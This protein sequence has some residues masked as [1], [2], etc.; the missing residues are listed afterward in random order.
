MYITCTLQAY[1]VTDVVNPFHKACSFIDGRCEALLSYFGFVVV[2]TEHLIV[3]SFC[4][5]CKL[6]F[7]VLLFL[8]GTN[9]KFPLLPSLIYKLEGCRWR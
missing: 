3:D 7:L 8:L 9:L 2:S 4:L 5:P 1:P 6:Y